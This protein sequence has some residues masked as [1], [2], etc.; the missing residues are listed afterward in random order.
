M[1]NKME[2]LTHWSIK[3]MGS[4]I[5]SPQTKSL[6]SNFWLSASRTCS[7]TWI[8]F[9]LRHSFGNFLI[10]VISGR[11][12]RKLWEISSFQWR[13]SLAIMMNF[14]KK[15]ER[16]VSISYITLYRLLL[17]SQRGE[18]CREEVLCLDFWRSGSKVY[19]RLMATAVQT[20]FINSRS[21]R[22][23]IE[24]LTNLFRFDFS[25]R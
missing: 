8:K 23:N 5:P 6:L 7:L 19:N 20:N 11:D 25:K 13:A 3:K 16:L 21:E 10:T 4:L 22:I 24:L 2:S 17:K 14:M 15:N 1:L 18:I 9:K 12:S